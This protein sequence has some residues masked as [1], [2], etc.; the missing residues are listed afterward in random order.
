VDTQSGHAEMLFAAVDST[1]RPIFTTYSRDGKT[2]YYC[3]DPTGPSRRSPPRLRS[4]NLESGEDKVFYEPSEGN[5]TGVL[6]LSPDGRSLAFKVR[7]KES[8]SLMVMPASGGQPREVL[9]SAA[10][11]QTWYGLA[12]SSDGR[13]LYNSARKDRGSPWDLWRVP[14]EGGAPQQ[15][16]VGMAVDTM[17][18]H[19]NG[20][21]IVFSEFQRRRFQVW[22]ME[23][24][25]PR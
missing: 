23:N 1:A 10:N 24:F 20:R 2:I 4:R 11:T 17:S 21:E 19:P 12:W 15:M 22:A 7:T 8:V 16:G 18:V 5:L 6:E 3:E 9:R 13:Y 14:V 25:L